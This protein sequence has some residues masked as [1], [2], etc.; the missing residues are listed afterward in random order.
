MW[1]LP[2]K[3]TS[4]CFFDLI[5]A[6]CRHNSDVKITNIFVENLSAILTLGILNRHYFSN[7]YF[8][9]DNVKFLKLAA[10]AKS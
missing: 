8:S 4:K 1:P 2:L 5:F 6:S 3:K 9:C 10:V 7:D